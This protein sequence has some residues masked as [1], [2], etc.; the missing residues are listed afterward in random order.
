MS[1]PRK[2]AAIKI[3]KPARKLGSASS[4]EESWQELESAIQQIY[5]KNSARLS[6]EQLY[7]TAYNLVLNKNGAQLYNGVKREVSQ[8]LEQLADEKIV[9]R[10]PNED[11]DVMEM[12]TF[13]KAVNEGYDHHAVSMGMVRDIL[14]YMVRSERREIF[15][16]SHLIPACLR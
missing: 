2:S 1:I 7:R 4:F 11:G 9:P 12:A 3:I 8:L 14:M 16:L 5:L 6:Y 15:R 10:F 13:L